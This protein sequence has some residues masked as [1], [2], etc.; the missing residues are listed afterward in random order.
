MN[1]SIYTS[2]VDKY[3]VRCN[4][5]HDTFQYLTFFQLADN[6]FFLLFDIRFDQSFVRYHYVLELVVDFHYFELHGLTYV[7]IVITDRFHIDLRTWQERLDAKYVNDHTSFG[8]TF[9]ESSNNLF[10]VVC[11]VNTLPRLD[12]SC[13]TVRQHQLTGFVFT[14]IYKYLNFITNF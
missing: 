6:L 1:Q 5:L 3:P 13:F 11:I 14:D 12:C 7:L 4:V 10:F 9:N 8:T 2:K